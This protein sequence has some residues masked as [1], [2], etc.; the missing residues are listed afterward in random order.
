MKREQI[1]YHNSEIALPRSI[2]FWLMLIFVV[3]SVIFTSLVLLYLLTDQAARKALHN[4]PVII[5]LCI[6]LIFQLTDTVW[7]LEFLQRGSVKPATPI[8]CLLWWFVDLGLYNTASLILSWATLERHILIFH[9]RWIATTNR[10]FLLHY[11]PLI[12]LLLYCFIYYIWILLDP[13]CEHQFIYD[14]PVC[15]ETP[16]H[17]L[18]PFFGIWETGIHGCL[19]TLIIAIFSIALLCRVIHQKRRLHQVFQWR[20][21]RKMIVQLISISMLYLVCNFP[22]MIISFT[23]ICCI[24]PDA[25]VDVQHFAFLL[26]YWVMFLLPFV[27][28]GSIQDLTKLY[29]VSH[30][31]NRLFHRRIASINCN[32]NAVGTR[33]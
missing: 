11:A 23:R 18:H 26:S 28:L 31:Y 3:P 12:L 25:W 30:C 6:A 19:S 32:Q 9:N 10:R 7:Y 8:R 1:L 22:I 21:Y 4:H 5:L 16:C 13:P 17:L 15:S 24:A 2:R 29:G 20:K 27:A 14:L 33:K